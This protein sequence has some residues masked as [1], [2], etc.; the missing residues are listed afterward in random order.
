MSVGPTAF[1]VLAAVLFCIGLAGAVS[2]KSA[3][4][5]SCR[6]SS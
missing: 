6:S 3:V 5:C 4:Q 1:M 2:K